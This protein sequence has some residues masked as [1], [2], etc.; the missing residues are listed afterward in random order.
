MSSEAI[1]II[2]RSDKMPVDAELLSDLDARDLL[3]VERQWEA[4]RHKIH[5]QLLAAGVSKSKWPESL[6]WN[7]SLK[8]SQLKQLA[9]KGF[10]IASGGELASGVFDRLRHVHGSKPGP[11]WQATGLSGLY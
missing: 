9:I 2:Q 11:P 7:W 8:S 5:Q 10:G 3:L 1:S 6:H 4:S